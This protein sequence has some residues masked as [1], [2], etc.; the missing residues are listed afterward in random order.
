MQ[1]SACEGEMS[2]VISGLENVCGRVVYIPGNVLL[3]L[4]YYSILYYFIF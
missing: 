2:S 3:I 4:L 1:V